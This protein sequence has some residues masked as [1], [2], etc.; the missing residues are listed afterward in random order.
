MLIV[1]TVTVRGAPAGKV[2]EVMQKMVG[3][4]GSPDKRYGNASF[5]EMCDIVETQK[6][7]LSIDR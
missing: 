7:D 3:D 5:R 2:T 4:S 6:G 1:V